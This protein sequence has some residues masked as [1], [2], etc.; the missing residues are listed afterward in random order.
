VA[1]SFIGGW[2]KVDKTLDWSQVIG[3][4]SHNVPSSTPRPKQL[5]RGEQSPVSVAKCFV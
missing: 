2:R 1:V 5:G 3:K 4:L